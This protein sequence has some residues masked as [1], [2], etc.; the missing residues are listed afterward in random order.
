M[1]SDVLFAGGFLLVVGLHPIFPV[2]AGGAVFAA[3]FEARDVGVAQ[4]ALFRRI[5]GEVLDPR[6]G[7]RAAGVAIE[8]VGIDTLAALQRDGDVATVVE[9]LLE[10]LA[11]VFVG[12]KLGNPTR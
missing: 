5:G 7:Q 11:Q 3:E 10:R 1:Q 4:L 6:I 12:G 8:N 9:C 2:L